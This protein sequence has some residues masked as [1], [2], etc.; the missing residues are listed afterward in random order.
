MDIAEVIGALVQIT[1]LLFVVG[2]L[3]AMGLALTVPMIL[4]SVSNVRL[5]AMGLVANS[6]YILQPAALDGSWG[7]SPIGKSAL[8]VGDVELSVRS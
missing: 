7:P 1:G 5:M 8:P 6:L 4:G 2:G 3:L